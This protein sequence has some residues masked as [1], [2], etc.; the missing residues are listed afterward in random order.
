VLPPKVQ[1][2]QIIHPFYALVVPEV[3]LVAQALKVI[4]KAS[5]RLLFSQI[6]QGFNDRAVVLF[7]AVIED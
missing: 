4:W 6:T 3:A 1:V 2:H 5:G 7:R